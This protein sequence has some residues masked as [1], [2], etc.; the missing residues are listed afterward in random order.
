VSKIAYTIDAAARELSGAKKGTV[1]T[2][3]VGALTDA[4]RNRTLPGRMLEGERLVI[5]RADLE[6]WVYSLPDWDK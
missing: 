4:I 5:L 2:H 1:H 3:W 6:K